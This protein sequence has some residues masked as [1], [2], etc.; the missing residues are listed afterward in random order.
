[1]PKY[2]NIEEL[3]RA[4]AQA[5]AN[6]IESGLAL[7]AAYAADLGRGW[8][9]PIEERMFLGLALA[10]Q[11]N[12]YAVDLYRAVKD[13]VRIV[14]DDLTSTPQTLINSEGTWEP[15]VHIPQRVGYAPHNEADFGFQSGLYA[16]RVYDQVEIGKYRAD[17]LVEWTWDG[18][19]WQ[20]LREAGEKPRVGAPAYVVIECDG[21][22]FHERT[23]EQARKDRRRDR[24]IQGLGLPVLRF[25]GSEI[26]A[27]PVGCGCQVIN[28]FVDAL[29]RQ[30]ER[31]LGHGILDRVSPEGD[32]R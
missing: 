25:T 19:Q 27:D 29:N 28:H 11:T 24:E 12:R 1:M 21:H 32:T 30:A 18:F 9:S 22:D 7:D 14:L 20:R 31:D 2:K 6:W 4:I 10:A 26:F 13:R 16:L 3:H 17:M 15:F 5:A 8:G 23:K